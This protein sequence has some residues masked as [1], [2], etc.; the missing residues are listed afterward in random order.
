MRRPA[1]NPTGAGVLLICAALWAALSL[2][3][4]GHV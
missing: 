2:I 4:G 1:I 3:G